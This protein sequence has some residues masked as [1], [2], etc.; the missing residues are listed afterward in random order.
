MTE[1]SVNSKLDLIARMR[2]AALEGKY[3]LFKS[4]LK[5]DI[6]LKVGANDELRD[7]QATVDFYID[8]LTTKIQVKNLE[9]K[10]TWEFD[11][12]AIV[13]YD[14]KANSA[15][16]NKYLQFPCVDIYHF[17]G[18]RVSEWHVYPMYEAFAAKG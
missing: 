7:P 1:Q 10:G 6:F 12:V 14:I 8:M 18:D 9:I 5:D 15:G 3:E 13:E 17:D 16:N 11:D 2:T 4:F